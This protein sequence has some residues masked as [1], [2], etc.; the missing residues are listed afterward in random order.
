VISRHAGYGV[1]FFNGTA[2][3]NGTTGSHAPT[4]GG[5]AVSVSGHNDEVW[6]AEGN[7]NTRLPVA[8]DKGASEEGVENA[9]YIVGCSGTNTHP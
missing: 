1:S 7:V 4:S 9:N 5:E 2:G 6:V 8:S 3:D